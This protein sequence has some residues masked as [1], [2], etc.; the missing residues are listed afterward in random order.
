VVYAIEQGVEQQRLKMLSRGWRD[1][2]AE[3]FQGASLAGG[4]RTTLYI[5]NLDRFYQRWG[6][7]NS[8]ITSFR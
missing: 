3:R 5:L 2:L 4:Y 8:A 7:R 6:L 1:A